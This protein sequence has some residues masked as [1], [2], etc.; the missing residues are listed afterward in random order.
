[1]SPFALPA[2]LAV[3]VLVVTATFAIARLRGRYDTIDTA[4]GAG[5]AVIAITSFAAGWTGALPAAL[6]V[7]WGIRLAVH[8]HRRNAGLSEDPRYVEMA[9]RAQRFPALRMYVRVYLVQGL[10]MWLV[11]MPVLLA[12]PGIGAWS[13]AGAAVWAVGMF[14]EVVGDEQLRRFRADPANAGEVLDTGLWRYTRHPNYFG[15]ACVWWGAYLMACQHWPGPLT[16]LSPLLMTW[17][18]AR[19]SGKPLLERRLRERRPAYADYVERTSGFLP[20]PPKRP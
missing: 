2:A 19:G 20:L 12:G 8:L 7:V 6:V 14:F 4:W 9:A 16:A 13:V 5:F 18:L 17:L 15:D 10:V 11:S 1:M 3:A